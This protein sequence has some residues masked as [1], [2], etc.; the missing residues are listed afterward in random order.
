MLDS[1]EPGKAPRWAPGT[2]KTS[3]KV[4][5]NLPNTDIFPNPSPFRVPKTLTVRFVLCRQEIEGFHTRETSMPLQEKEP[6]PQTF[7]E[8]MKCLAC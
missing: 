5:V 4:K 8:P 2:L 3:T 1:E 7:E 6:R